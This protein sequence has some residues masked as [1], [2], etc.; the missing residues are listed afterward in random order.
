MY[1][2]TKKD[3]RKKTRPSNLYLVLIGRLMTNLT[4]PTECLLPS[5]Q[6]QSSKQLAMDMNRYLVQVQQ[7]FLDGRAI[8]ALLDHLNSILNDVSIIYL[9]SQIQVI[10][11][12]HL[13]WFMM[14]QFTF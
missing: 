6:G 7:A 11:S 9:T 5:S 14:I 8:Q 3:K 13:K 1:N 4:Q 12:Q 2:L 10:C